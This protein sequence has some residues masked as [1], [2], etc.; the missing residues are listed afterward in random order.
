MHTGMHTICTGHHVNRS[1]AWRNCTSMHMHMHT[2]TRYAYAYPGTRGRGGSCLEGRNAPRDETLQLGG[3]K[4]VSQCNFT[5][6]KFVKL[7]PGT[8]AALKFYYSTIVRICTGYPGTG[9][10]SQTPV[11]VARY[12]VHI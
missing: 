3:H 4:R 10:G 5:T 12:P 2:S 6:L 1:H 11:Q 7:V 8:G 9:T